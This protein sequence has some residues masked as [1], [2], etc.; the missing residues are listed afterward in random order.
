M[1]FRYLFISLIT[2]TLNIAKHLLYS[3][4]SVRYFLFT[5]PVNP[6]NNPMKSVYY[7]HSSNKE[8]K[9]EELKNL[10]QILPG[11][12]GFEIQVHLNSKAYTLH[13]SCGGVC[14]HQSPRP[15]EIS[16]G[17]GILRFLV[18]SPDSIGS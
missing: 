11:E 7:S 1:P 17:G 4:Y 3:R 12:T 8:T 2:G 16:C 9:A 15:H 6:H 10:L 5:V 14:R 13:H 18:T